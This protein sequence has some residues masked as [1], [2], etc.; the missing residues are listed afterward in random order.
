MYTLQQKIETKDTNR[1]AQTTKTCQRRRVN[2]KGVGKGKTVEARA[3]DG[4]FYG[5]PV[6]RS[7]VE[8]LAHE[9]RQILH[10]WNSSRL[11]VAPFHSA[12]DVCLFTGAHAGG[13]FVFAAS[14]SGSVCEEMCDGTTCC[15]EMEGKKCGYVET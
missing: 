2:A 11:R 9:M 8:L 1:P 7:S 6:E 4:K 13:G 5:M 3:S 10:C 12:Q 14:P 15:K